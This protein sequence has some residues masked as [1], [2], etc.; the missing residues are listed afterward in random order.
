MTRTA[1]LRRLCDLREMEERNEAS[2]LA[3]ATAVLRKIDD[4]LRNVR[5]YEEAARVLIRSGVQRDDIVDRLAGAG[6]TDLAARLVKGLEKK[7]RLGEEQVGMIRDQYLA[8]RVE[9]RRVEAILQIEM[10][11]EESDAQRRTQSLLDEWHRITGRETRV[12]SSEEDLSSEKPT[13]SG[14]G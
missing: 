2:R 12:E 3:L 8:K 6:E 5:G 1:R 11:R 4:A 10:E 7:R 9:R 14:R 13:T